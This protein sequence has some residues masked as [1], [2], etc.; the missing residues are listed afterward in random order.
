MLTG[1]TDMLKGINGGFEVNRVVGAFGAIAFIVG[2]NVFVGYEVFW[3]GKDFD[4]TAYCLA[5]PG[6]LAAL[7]LGTGAAVAIKDRNVA[8]SR[9]VEATGSK[10]ATPP[11]PAPHV[12]PEL[13]AASE[14]AQSGQPAQPAQ[15]E[16]T[17]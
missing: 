14:A 8:A 6:G 1:L 9:V 10:P 7:G 12:Q 11:Q 2:T 5:F 17:L 15:E 4:L 3:L 16:A 13:A